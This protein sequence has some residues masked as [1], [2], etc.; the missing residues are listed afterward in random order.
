MSYALDRLGWLQF[1]QLCAHVLAL[2][3]GVPPA[4]WQGDADETRTVVLDEGLGPPLLA[5]PTHE[6]VLVHCAWLRAGSMSPVTAALEQLS[7]ERLDDLRGLRSYVLMANG[8]AARDRPHPAVKG[9]SVEVIDTPALSARIDALPEL[10]LAMPSLLGLRALDDLVPSAAAGPSTLDRGEAERLADVFVPTRAYARA[11]RTLNEHHL[12]VLTGPPEMGKTATARMI[13]LAKMTDGWQAHECTSPDQM[14]ASVDPA[15]AQVFI[16]D[17]AFGSTEY[18]ADSAELWARAMEQ[19]LGALD[20]RHWLIWTSRPAPLHAALHRLHQERGAERFP[21]PARVL[22][23]A[24]VLD[25]EEKV[26]ILFRHAKAAQL[27]QYLCRGLQRSGPMIVSLPTFTPERIRRCVL[28]LSRGGWDVVTAAER[29]LTTPTE[30][31]ATSFG[32]LGDEHRDVL[33]ALLDT[34]PGPVAERELVAA[35]RRHHDGSLSRPPLHL[36]DRLADHFLRVSA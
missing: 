30:A 11:V 18:R 31:M 12:A 15:A 35:L 22:V 16:A 19:L 21:A 17:D 25:D 2:D 29:E 13:A 4:D 26:L 23:D 27:P 1:Q 36:V 3:A 24:A 6:R 8:T 28:R 14:L 9:L 10:R 7:L 20:D 32:A 33:V 5:S 34:P